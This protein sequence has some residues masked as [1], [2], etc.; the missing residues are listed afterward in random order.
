MKNIFLTL[1]LAVTCCMGVFADS[2]KNRYSSRLTGEGT[3][4]FI[5]D[6]KLTKL[7]NI[8]KFK[9]DMTYVDSNDTIVVNFTILAQTP[10][11]PKE[12]ILKGDTK[13]FTCNEVERFYIDITNKGY[14][15]RLSTKFHKDEIKEIVFSKTPP[16]FSFKMGETE[17]SATYSKYAWKKD[18]KKLQGIFTLIY[19]TDK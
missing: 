4:Y 9:Y 2:T 17:V 12:V 1:L 10:D 11:V 5:R 16:V 14:E 6:K 8:S 15:L 19:Y 13:S 7:E 18:S 3:C